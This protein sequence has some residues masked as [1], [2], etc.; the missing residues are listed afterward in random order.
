MIQREKLILA[1]EG[2]TAHNKN[3]YRNGLCGSS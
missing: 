2:G 3:H 1:T